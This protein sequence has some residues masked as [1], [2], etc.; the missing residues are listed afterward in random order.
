MNINIALYAVRSA[1]GSIDHECTLAK[2]A[3][4]LARFAAERETE[5]ADIG[6]AV[7]ALFDQYRGARLNTPFVVGE[8]LRRLEAKPENYKALSDKVTELIR[9]QAQ[10]ATQDDGSV[11]NPNSVFLIGKGKGGGIARRADMK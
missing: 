4:D 6:K 5:M 1:Q 7:H 8:T 10:G 9:S 2:F 3:G 11:E